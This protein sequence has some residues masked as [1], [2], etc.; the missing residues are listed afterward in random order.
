MLF[1]GL[2]LALL[3][4]CGGSSD[5]KPTAGAKVA[6]AKVAEGEAG[7][8]KSDIKHYDITD[9]PP[10][11]EALQRPLDGGRLEICPPAD[12]GFFSQANYLV[13][14]AK[15]KVSELP[16]IT[17]A[18][19]DSPFGTADTSED[20][21]QALAK[22]IQRKL[23]KDQKTVREKPKPVMLGGRV[24]VRHVRQ[25]PQGGSPC[26]VQ[27]LQTVCNERLYTLEAFSAAKDDSQASIAAAVNKDNL[28]DVTYAVAAN[29][30]FIKGTGTAAATPTTP[31]P[32]TPT[33]EKPPEAKAAETPPAETKPAAPPAVPPAAEKP[34]EP[35]PAEKKTE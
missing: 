25:V 16:R 9:L 13:V 5:T 30:K 2:A 11:D 32:T 34:A 4:G 12:W 33:P 29:A 22:N 21:S 15:K 10:V 26:A 8:P 14:F 28:R 31:A 35:K 6:G 23:E 17:V 24:W 18:A 7:G 19:A 1:A 20:N 3:P 27:S